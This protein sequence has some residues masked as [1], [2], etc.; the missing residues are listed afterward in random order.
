M[1][2]AKAAQCRC[3]IQVTGLADMTEQAPRD[4]HVG[5]HIRARGVVS[6]I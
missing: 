5:G 3:G 4:Y 6:D 2:T 1:R